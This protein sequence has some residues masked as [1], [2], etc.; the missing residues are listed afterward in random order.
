MK[1][2]VIRNIGAGLGLAAAIVIGS[3]A[4]AFAH[5]CINSSRSDQGNAKAGANSQSWWTLDVVGAI[6]GDAQAG[7]ITT[8]QA[9]CIIAAYEATGAP[10][11]FTIKVKGANGQDGTLG[12]KNP[13]DGLMADG[14]G[15]DHLFDAYGA[16]IFGS[17]AGCGASLG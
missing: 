11:S 5:E 10:M 2:A 3:G 1:K 8:Q 15:I 6:Y 16:Q 17:Y 7:Y 12:A 14:K 9:E 13:N 4:G